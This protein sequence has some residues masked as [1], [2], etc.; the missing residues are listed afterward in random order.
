VHDLAEAEPARVAQ[1]VDLWWREAERCNVLPLDNR[2]LYTILN[3]RPSRLRER[4]RYRYLPHGAP[5]PESVAVDTRNRSHEI[6]VAVDVADGVTPDGALLALGCV[7]G[8]W[9]L[10]VLEGRL[11]YVHNLYGKQLDVVTSDALIGAGVHT[12]GF[13]YE[14]TTDDG[15]SGTLLVDGE[16]VGRGDIPKFTPTSFN[17]T[18]AGLTCGYEL[19]P[20]V[21]EGY[22]APFR[23]TGS[24]TEAI[25]E[26]TG[27]P[28][29]DPLAEFEKIM[30]EQ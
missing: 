18:N 17:N 16:V 4:T 22:E 11:R 23:F 6:T 25:V 26:V 3:P 14:R 5:V 13:V 24:I 10:H 8:G 2:I 9:S 15:G 20:P 12:L 30:A 1:M 27:V 21:G 19:G 29:P 7:L 28:R